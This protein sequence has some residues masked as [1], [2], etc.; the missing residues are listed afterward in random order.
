M[1]MVIIWLMMV[2]NNLVGGFN[3]PLKNDGVS[4]GGIDIYQPAEFFF[5]FFALLV[6]VCF[7]NI[8]FFKLANQILN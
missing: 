7:A 8:Q 4:G 2:N 1:M 6:E 3:Q 5:S